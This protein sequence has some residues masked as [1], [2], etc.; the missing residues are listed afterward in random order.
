M[1]KSIASQRSLQSSR[2][3]MGSGVNRNNGA[4]A[5]DQDGNWGGALMN[6]G[7]L[8]GFAAFSLV[9]KYICKLIINEQL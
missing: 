2:N 1:S 6:L 4:V 9:V 5:N 3:S 8:L 7:V